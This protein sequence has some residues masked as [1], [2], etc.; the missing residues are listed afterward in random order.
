MSLTSSRHAELQKTTW[1]E[2]SV[3]LP[4][5]CARWPIPHSPYDVA[6]LNVLGVVCQKIQCLIES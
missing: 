3:H 6:I 1:C 2:P 5:G 4:L